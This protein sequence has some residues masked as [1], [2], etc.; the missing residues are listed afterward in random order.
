MPIIKRLE[1]AELLYNAAQAMGLEPTWITPKGMFAF[2]L[3]GSETYVNSSVSPLNPHAASSLARNKNLTR[4]VLERHGILNIPF[5]KTKDMADALAFLTAHQQII[6]KPN[7]GS[8]SEDIHIITKAS[9]LQLLPISQYILE[10]Y[11]VGTEYRCLV[12]EGSVIA[13]HIS[14]YGTSVA[15]DRHLER[16]SLPEADWDERL[17]TTAIEASEAIGLQFAAVDFMM[18]A[19][20]NAYVLEVNSP[21]GLKWFHA[22]TS[23]PPVNIARDFLESLIRSSDL[24]YIT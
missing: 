5:L 1:S 11:I 10:R 21:P 20:H 6:A 13:V 22:P 4:L 2:D 24:A 19:T 3:N 17:V 14:E 9:E 8:G 18:V 15:A 23:G 12:L 16:Y 7:R